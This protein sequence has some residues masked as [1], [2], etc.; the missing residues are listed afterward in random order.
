VNKMP[1]KFTSDLKKVVIELGKSGLAVSD[2]KK[3][4]ESNKK[5]AGGRD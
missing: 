2:E 1:F 4:E 5:L 3:L